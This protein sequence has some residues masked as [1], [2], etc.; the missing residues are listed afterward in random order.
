VGGHKTSVGDGF[1]CRPGVAAHVRPETHDLHVHSNRSKDVEDPRATFEGLAA[2]GRE[3]GIAIGF[4]DHFEATYLDRPTFCFHPGNVG[5]Y[6]EAYDR[7]KAAFPEVTLGIEVEH[8]PLRPDLNALTAEWLDRHR[9][10]FDRVLGSAH[11]VFDT[12]AVT[13]EHDLR[14]ALR[15]HTYREVLAAYLDGLDSLVGSGVADCLPHADAV[16]RGNAAL[17]D[18]TPVERAAADAR[19]LG[20]CR[21]AASLGMA[22]EVNLIGAADGSGTGPSPPWATVEA[23]AREGARVFVGSDSH[24]HDQLPRAAPH[25]REACARLRRMGARTLV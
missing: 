4:A 5:S 2:L 21:R 24:G 17:M 15:V 19:V 13:W 22:I 23:V 1:L 10:E 12:W 14:L 16:F 3:L 25:V 11:F 6:L 8:Y 20:A 9:R 7:A 18:I